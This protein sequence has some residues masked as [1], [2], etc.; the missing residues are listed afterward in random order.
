M[1]VLVAG[2]YSSLEWMIQRL[3]FKTHQICYDVYMNHIR[4]DF[5]ALPDV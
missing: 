5:N 2:L 3:L 1:A 4:R